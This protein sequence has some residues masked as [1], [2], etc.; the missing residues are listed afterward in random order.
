MRA[1]ILAFAALIGVSA[2]SLGSVSGPSS[3]FGGGGAE[4]TS[5]LAAVTEGQAL[6][7]VAGI[8]AAEAAPTRHGVI[9]R[10]TGIAA[11]QGYYN[12]RLVPAAA[13]PPEGGVLTLVF[14]ADPPDRAQP[15]GTVTGR[16]IMAAIFLHESDL[17]QVRSIRIESA[18]NAVTVS[19]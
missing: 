7:R 16:R 4:R 1:T 10:A 6:P 2:C 18:S 12:A 9:I 14:L 8:A 13:V 17:P 3:W 11:T 5:D 15:V 19:R